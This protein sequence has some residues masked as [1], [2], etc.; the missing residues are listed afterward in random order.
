MKKE[1][2]KAK[3][4][5]YAI[6]VILALASL[7]FRLLNQY[8]LE[9][10]ALLFVGI[11][12]F[13][14]VLIIKY[15]KTPKSVYGITFYSI[16]LFL[17]M[18]AILFGEGLVCIIFMAP[19][20]YGVAALIILVFQLFKKKRKLNVSLLIPLLLFVG[21]A[22]Q[23]NKTAAVQHIAT[24]VSVDGDLS[25]SNLLKHPDFNKNLPLFFQLG[26]PKPQEMTGQG[27]ALNDTRTITFLSNTKGLGS[28][29]LIVSKRT[30]NSITFSVI[31][32]STHINHWLAYKDITVSTQNL[33]NKTRITWTTNYVCNL[34]P[35]WYFETL[36]NYAVAKMNQHLINSFYN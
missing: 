14:T 33:G 36:E 1:S 17:M 35:N 4:T 27:I 11:P 20:F 9:Q 16:T 3:N 2:Q 26:F 22:N 25:I 18:T 24:Q 23:F 7:L 15:T 6:V 31:D 13:I 30:Q 19:I 21:Q 12:A 28:L 32:D 10:S 8:K 29:K 34:A 5:L